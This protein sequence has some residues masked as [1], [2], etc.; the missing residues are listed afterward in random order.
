MGEGKVLRDWMGDLPW[1]MQSVIL[2]ALRG[3]DTQYS[4]NLK[5][6]VRWMRVTTQ[7]NADPSHSYMQQ[8]PL[9]SL[10]DIEKEVVFSNLHYVTHLLHA[11]EIIG[12]KHPD[13]GVAK[14]AREY[15]EGIA[16]EFFHLNPETESQL[17]E[18]LKDVQ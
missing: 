9:P 18:R 7:N 14:T 15:Y 12:Y 1:K 17:E 4:P 11:I 10:D 2:S 16:R 3:P 13:K 6:V 8:E 5:K